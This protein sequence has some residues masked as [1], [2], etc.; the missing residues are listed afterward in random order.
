MKI[1]LK[2]YGWKD[3]TIT[4][5]L[6]NKSCVCLIFLGYEDDKAQ[7]PFTVTDL[8][9]RNLQLVTESHNGQVNVLFYFILRYTPSDITLRLLTGTVNNTARFICAQN[10]AG[11][12]WFFTLHSSATSTQIMKIYKIS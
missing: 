4:L 1:H 11:K 12:T 3:E 10:S 7:L 5:D 6:T 8:K 9:G 2:P